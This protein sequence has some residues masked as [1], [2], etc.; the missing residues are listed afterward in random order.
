MVY[1][2]GDVLK[3]KCRREELLRTKGKKVLGVYMFT[4][5]QKKGMLD[6]R[7][8]SITHIYHQMAKLTQG[9][10][11]TGQFIGKRGKYMYHVAFIH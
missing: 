4:S 9:L 7:F 3:W 1:V 2:A 6:T 8:L 10:L 5:R 11:G